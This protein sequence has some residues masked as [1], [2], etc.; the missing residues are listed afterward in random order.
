MTV[1]KELSSYSNI[2]QWISIGTE[3][4]AVL[5]GCIMLLSIYCQQIKLPFNIRC[6]ATVSI[7]CFIIHS[8]L[9]FGFLWYLII[10]CVEYLWL[11]ECSCFAYGM[12]QLFKYIF[13]IKRVQFLFIETDYKELYTIKQCTLYIIYFIHV[14]PWGT[15]LGSGKTNWKQNWKYN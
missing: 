10:N 6:H 12:A 14:Y 4:F 13:F 15:E 3:S 2:T 8:I 11:A 5:F 9:A 1:V 7:I